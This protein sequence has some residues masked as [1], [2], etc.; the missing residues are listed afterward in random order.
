MGPSKVSLVANNN[1][2]DNTT[3]DYTTLTILPHPSCR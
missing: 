2:E 3:N 1:R